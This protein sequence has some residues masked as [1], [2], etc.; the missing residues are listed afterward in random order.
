MF[1]PSFNTMKGYILFICVPGIVG[2][3]FEITQ[4]KNRSDEGKLNKKITNLLL[5]LIFIIMLISGIF[6][7]VN[8]T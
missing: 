3:C 5:I 1:S 8:L 2:V 7:Y 6:V 4:K